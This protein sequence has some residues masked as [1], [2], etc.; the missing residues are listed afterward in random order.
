M[1]L[2]DNI[3]SFFDA[4]VIHIIFLVLLVVGFHWSLFSLYFST[5]ASTTKTHSPTEAAVLAEIERLTR[6]E[7]I[8]NTQQRANQ[9]ALEIHKIGFEQKIIEK[10][11]EK[12]WLQEQQ[13]V[14]LN[15]L[16]QLKQRQLSEERQLK[17]LEREIARF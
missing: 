9:Y 5:A 15:A 4:L 7:E 13:A 3:V 1:T 6:E 17:Q 14:E 10:Q 8:K 11:E 2:W 12:E 16:E